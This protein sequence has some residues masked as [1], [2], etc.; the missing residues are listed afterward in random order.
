QGIVAGRGLWVSSDESLIYYASGTEIRRWTPTEG[1]TTIATGFSEL[2][3]ITVDPF[4]GHVVATDRFAHA[5]YKIMDD[6]TKLR[7]AGNE[8][9]TGGTSGNLATSVG[10]NEVRTIEFDT[11]GGYYLGTHRG[12]QI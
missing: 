8:S 2:G 7:I 6:G 3:N 4:D 10:L 12:S 9:T 5:V 11:T 1:V